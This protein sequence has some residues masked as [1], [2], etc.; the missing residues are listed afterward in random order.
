MRAP[1]LAR[2]VVVLALLTLP[3]PARGAP[4]ARCRAERTG[5]RALVTVELDGL[6]DPE[7]LHLVRLGLQGRLELEAT[8]WQARPLWFDARLATHAATLALTWSEPERRFLLDGEPVAD[9]G[10]IALPP[11]ALPVGGGRRYVH[12][13]ARLEVV[14]AESLGRVARWMVG[15]GD[16]RGAGAGRAGLSRAL[17]SAVAEDLERRADASC[18]GP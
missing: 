14:T 1:R 12:L 8:L 5:P 15:G 16:E 9:P 17:L 4:V 7:L 6:A 10:R 2:G 3:L 18:P 11:F 13:A